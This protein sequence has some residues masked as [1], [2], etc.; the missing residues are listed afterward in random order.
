MA[1]AWT[2]PFHPHDEK[3]CREALVETKSLEADPWVSRSA[4]QGYLLSL[5]H[6]HR[7]PPQQLYGELRQIAGSWL[8]GRLDVAS[9]S[10]MNATLVDCVELFHQIVVNIPDHAGLADDLASCSLGQI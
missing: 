10:E 8:S 7:R 6:P 2:R 9:R 5:L 4:F 3:M 1:E